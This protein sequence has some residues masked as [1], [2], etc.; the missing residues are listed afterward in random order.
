MFTSFE[1]A[2]PAA[3]GAGPVLLTVGEQSPR[4]RHES[5]RRLAEKFGFAVRELPGAHHAVHLDAPAVFAATISQAA[6][7]GPSD[8]TGGI[9]ADVR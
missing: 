2:A 1:P 7:A 8:G 6:G 4:P 5:V 9:G 3:A